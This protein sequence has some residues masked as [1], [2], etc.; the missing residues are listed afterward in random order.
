MLIYIVLLFSFL[1]LFI[2][3]SLFLYLI[4][5][6]ATDKY[7]EKKKVKYR[8]KISPFLNLYLSNDNI[9][10]NRLFL[11]KKKWKRDIIIE[12]LYNKSATTKN[13]EEMIKI[14]GLCKSIGLTDELSKR[15]KSKNWWI[16]ADATR[17]VGRLKLTELTP[18]LLN[19][20]QSS[21]YDVWTTSAR[22]LGNMGQINYLIKLLIEKESTLERWS[23]I[24]IGDILIQ[25]NQG[26]FDIIIDHLD[27]VSA[28]L[29][30]IFIETLGK[31]KAVKALP[32]IEKY[33]ESDNIELRL[34]ALKAIGEI[35]IT[36]NENKILE[37]ISSSNWLEAVMAI[38]TAQKCSIRQSIPIL[39]TLISNQNWWVRLRSAEAIYSFGIIGKE[40]L[41]WISRFHEDPYAKNMAEKVLL[42]ANLR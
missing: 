3:I 6:K 31:R 18:L 29:K 13:E 7:F 17:K 41:L 1:L 33:L 37:L 23:L 14:S 5:N 24:R 16:V 10:L 12:F 19:N 35:G 27:N 11:T 4:F 25:A 2:L 32:V 39:L 26:D 8:K 22:A 30:G 42:E 34:K 20:L 38:Q 40:K 28:L 9:P 36:S 21:E 15:L